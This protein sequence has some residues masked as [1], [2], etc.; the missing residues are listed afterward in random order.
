[1]RL[2]CA[3]IARWHIRRALRHRAHFRHHCD[4]A[5]AWISSGRRYV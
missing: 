5:D 3:L 4:R 2:L 1:M